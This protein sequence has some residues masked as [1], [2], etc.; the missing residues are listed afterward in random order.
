MTECS[1]PIPFIKP[2]DNG[3]CKPTVLAER[4]Y[5]N[6]L[7][8]C[9]A[10]NGGIND[11][12]NTLH[13]VNGNRPAKISVD[14]WSSPVNMDGSRLTVTNSAES[15]QK[16]NFSNVMCQSSLRGEFADRSLPTVSRPQRIVACVTPM[17]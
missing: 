9:N 13:G 1:T 14:N 12:G 16:S 10:Y 7:G 6:S 5:N 8:T 3:N 15:G 17:R 11:S 4:N 2:Q